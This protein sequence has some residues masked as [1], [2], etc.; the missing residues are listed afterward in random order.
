MRTEDPLELAQAIV[1][2]MRAVR[3][4]GM[5]KAEARAAANKL[6]AD[7]PEA[8]SALARMGK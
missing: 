4:K 6:F 3:E 1:G 2:L 5:P 7:N 8:T